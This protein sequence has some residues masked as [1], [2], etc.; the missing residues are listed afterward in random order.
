[1]QL[2]VQA[3]SGQAAIWSLPF[4]GPWL[5]LRYLATTLWSLRSS[6]ATSSG[7]KALLTP[8]PYSVKLGLI[9]AAIQTGRV[10]D[11]K[12]LFELLKGRPLRICPPARAVVSATFIK[13]WKIDVC[14]D[15]RGNETED[16]YSLRVRRKCLDLCPH[17]DSHLM[18]RVPLAELKRFMRETFSP[19]VGFREYV[20][21]AGDGEDAFFQ[22]ALAAPDIG[23]AERALVA[24]AAVACTYFG[25]RGCFAR[26]VPAASEDGLTAVAE[27]RT[28]AS[29]TLPY[30]VWRLSSVPV[31]LGTIQVLDELTAASRWDNVSTYGPGKVYAAKEGTWALGRQV[32]PDRA[33]VETLIPYRLASSSKS[34]TYYQRV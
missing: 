9:D 29:Y 26:F 8:T 3:S 20:E 18:S 31:R 5:V 25:K 19:T 28:D 2:G 33:F 16:E 6:Q 11:G 15:K 22:V 30:S 27:L 10:S 4:E 7:G 12:R 24:R 34:Y 1:M 17:S 13:L 21:F 32:E 14:P 23:A